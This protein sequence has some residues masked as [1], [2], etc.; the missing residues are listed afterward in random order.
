[1]NSWI[2]PPVSV[3]AAAVWV[4]SHNKMTTC[5]L[6]LLLLCG[7]GIG[8]NAYCH[9]PQLTSCQTCP[10][11]WTWYGG[12]CY[13]FD[14][15]ERDWYD[16]ERFC[17]SKGASLESLETQSEYE[18]VRELI[19]RSKGS[20]VPAWVGGYDAVKEG[21]WFWSDGTPFTFNGWSPGEPSN[22]GGNEN[23]MMINLKN[24]DYINDAQCSIKLGAVCTR[25]P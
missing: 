23:C 24:R 8:A 10:P 4:E 15:T 1:M 11:G 2:L 3:A 16:S 5:L 12:F 25:N 6:S 9:P 21:V 20:D 7:L 19:R 17:N 14:A 22:S 13:M 18:F